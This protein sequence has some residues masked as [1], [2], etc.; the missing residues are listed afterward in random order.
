MKIAIV[1][2][3]IPIPSANIINAFKHSQGFYN[4]GHNVE[5]LGVTRFLDDMWKFIGFKPHN[6]EEFRLFI[7]NN[8][9]MWITCR[10]VPKTVD[11]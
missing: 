6:K 2:N 4:L 5:I 3:Y 8:K 9:K 11:K 1:K 7:E 10:L